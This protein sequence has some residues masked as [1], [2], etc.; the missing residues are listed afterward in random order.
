[1]GMAVL[2]EPSKLGTSTR[3]GLL[4]ACKVA[5]TRRRQS[6][7][8]RTL[9]GTESRDA[10]LRQGSRRRATV[11]A[12]YRGPSKRARDDPRCCPNSRSLDIIVLHLSGTRPFPRHALH[13]LGSENPQILFSIF[14]LALPPRTCPRTHYKAVAPCFT[15]VAIAC[16]DPLIYPPRLSGP[17]RACVLLA[18]ATSATLWA[19]AAASNG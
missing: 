9:S 19:E 5:S 12:L 2:C 18:A 7:A 6:S 15:S 10:L 13:G 16:K 14:D 11:A 8:T 17:E 3:P 4:E 1:M